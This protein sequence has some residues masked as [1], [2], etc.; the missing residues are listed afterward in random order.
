MNF[1]ARHVCRFAGLIQ[2]KQM[3]LNGLNYVC[4][5]SDD[6]KVWK[7]IKNSSP[8]QFCPCVQ[9]RY[10][11]MHLSMPVCALTVDLIVEAT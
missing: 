2:F 4:C 7:G 3:D 9:S 1:N 8:L 11:N 5:C 10:V 6:K